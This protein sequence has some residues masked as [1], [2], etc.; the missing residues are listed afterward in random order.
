MLSG[1]EC[2]LV[3]SLFCGSGHEKL[4]ASGV[5]CSGSCIQ[6]SRLCLLGGVGQD[7]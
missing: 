1:Q 7:M 2:L 6:M 4:Q 5:E 3:F